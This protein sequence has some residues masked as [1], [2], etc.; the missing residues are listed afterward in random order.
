MKQLLNLKTSAI[1]HLSPVPGPL[2]CTLK[3]E[4]HSLA[5]S[6]IQPLTLRR[7]SFVN[8]EE[9]RIPRKWDPRNSVLWL[10]CTAAGKL[11]NFDPSFPT[12]W[13]PSHSGRSS[14]VQ[15]STLE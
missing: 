12:H 13:N 3:H 6:P 7:I 15:Q 8:I 4:E 2:T 5:K 11:A 9:C 10:Q 14:A 1:C